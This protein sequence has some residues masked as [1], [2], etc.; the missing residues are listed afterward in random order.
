MNRVSRIASDKAELI[1]WWDA[2]RLLGCNGSEEKFAEAL[3][4]VR[5]CRHPDAVWLA[6]LLPAGT[7]VTAELLL[8]SVRAQHEE[9]ARALFLESML[10]P[11]CKRE[12]RDAAVTSL[13]RAA[14]LGYAP[15]QAELSRVLNARSLD[16]GDEALEWA[17]K[18]A[19]Q[20]HRDGMARVADFLF[21][22]W[23]L[24]KDE[25]RAVALFKEAAELG[26]LWAQH[27]Y[28]RLAFGERDWQRYNWWGRAGGEAM[29]NL[30]YA[31]VDL[32]ALFEAGQ[33]GRVL[34]EV[35]LAVKR[36]FE[37]DDAIGITNARM[38]ELRRVV[39]LYESRCALA[40][41]AV[42]CWSG[43]GRRLGLVKD[44]RL[45][46]AKRAWDERWAWCGTEEGEDEQPEEEARKRVRGQ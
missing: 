24:D 40:R 10:T 13:R 6:S 43:V 44:M 8:Q 42:D 19:A 3:Q 22:G 21:N 16:E 31:A 9:D 17:Q 12:G 14:Q 29:C 37:E 45:M 7:V 38:I 30:L 11:L 15:A 2:L 1:K 20:G 5:E 28:G 25:A 36:H 33:L 39:A 4:L 23:V 32:L 34:F 26:S 35:A 46:V 27:R 18:A 41:E